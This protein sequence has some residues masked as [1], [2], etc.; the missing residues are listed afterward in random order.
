[1]RVARHHRGPA[2]APRE[3]PVAA[4]EPQPPER[5]LQRRAVA[6]EALLREQGTDLGLEELDLRRARPRRLGAGVDTGNQSDGQAQQSRTRSETHRAPHFSAG[7]TP[8]QG[9]GT[10]LAT[11]H[12]SFWR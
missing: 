8:T 4:V 10:E 9:A 7:A 11:S 3:Q 6:L 12:G 2:V 5:R 1:M